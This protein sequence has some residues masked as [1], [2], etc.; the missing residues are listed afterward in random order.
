M[1]GNSMWVWM[2]G[3]GNPAPIYRSLRYR[4]CLLEGH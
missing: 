3:I 1:A 4:G 2:W